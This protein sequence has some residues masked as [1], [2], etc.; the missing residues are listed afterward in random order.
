[1]NVVELQGVAK[2]FRFARERTRSLR[3]TVLDRLNGVPPAEYFWAVRDLDLTV[4]RGETLGLVGPNGAG[5]STVL[6]LIAGILQPT[7]GQVVTRGSVT[8]LL[9]LGAGFHA[10]YT[11]RENI[12][13]FGS[14]HGL[15][16]RQV[17]ARFE[18][19]TEFSELGRFIDQPVK[20]YSSGMYVR[21]AFSAAIA[22]EPEILLLDEVLAVGDE[23]FRNK[24]FTW[25][26]DLRDRQ[27]TIVLVSHDLGK[28]SEL[29]S[30]AVWIDGGTCRAQGEA[31]TVIDAYLDTVGNARPARVSLQR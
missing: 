10:E 11:G 9:D 31:D 3:Q 5:K 28:V 12:Y 18:E 30:R 24:C 19:I 25:I 23:H 1:V 4:R 8:A 21:L 17:D 13:L 14:F 29:C 6:K 22:L 2:K 7:L 26:S 20:H 15:G 16:R 27:T